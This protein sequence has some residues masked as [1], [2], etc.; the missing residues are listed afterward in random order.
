MGAKVFDSDEEYFRWLVDNPTGFVLNTWRPSSP[1]YIV[2]HRAS[3]RHISE[4]TH[5]N[6]PGGFTERRYAKIGATDI[7]ALR[8][9]AAEHGR[10]DR[11]FSNECSHCKPTIL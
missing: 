6:E 5:E 1:S 11:S 2:L 8:D 4:P 7:E 10:P 9:W 3:C